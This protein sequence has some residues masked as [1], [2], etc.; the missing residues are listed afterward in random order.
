MPLTPSQTNDFNRYA[1]IPETWVLSAR[2]SLSVVKILSRHLDDLRSPF[3]NRDVVE[4]SGCHNASY[5]HAAVAVENAAKAVLVARDP[6]VVEN[7]SLNVKKFGSRSG[8]GL[9]DPVQSILGALTDKEARY[10]VKLEE[11]VW[12]GRYAVPMRADVLYDEEKM[13][14]LRLSTPDEMDMLH[15]LVERLIKCIYK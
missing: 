10:L 2:R 11:F 12:A 14:V 1:R 8:H 15:S 7:G 5:F 3:V 9:L 13:D 6:S 4:F